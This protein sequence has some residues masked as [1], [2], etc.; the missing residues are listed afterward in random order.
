MENGA[1]EDISHIDI[2][3]VLM[4]LVLVGVFFRSFFRTAMPPE[5]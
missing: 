1:M 5:C 3:T 4:I 2:F